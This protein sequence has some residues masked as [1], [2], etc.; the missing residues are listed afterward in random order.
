MPKKTF[1]TAQKGLYQFCNIKWAWHANLGRFLWLWLFSQFLAWNSKQ[2]AV[3]KSQ[4]NLRL[5][6]Q[7]ANRYGGYYY[8]VNN[9]CLPGVC[10]FKLRLKDKT[11]LVSTG[12]SAGRETDRSHLRCNNHGRKGMLQISVTYVVY[13]LIFQY[14][15]AY[16]TSNT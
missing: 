9:A 6:G 13:T 1:F 8:V 10:R 5:F 14:I 11:Q 12:C 7:R 2:P 16:I 3:T 15:V 4:I